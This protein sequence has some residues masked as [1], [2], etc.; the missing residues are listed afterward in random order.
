MTDSYHFGKLP[1]ILIASLIFF[2]QCTATKKPMAEANSKPSI[3]MTVKG[4]NAVATIQNFTH[5]AGC[6]YLFR[7]KDGTLLLPGELPQTDIPFY[8][9]AGIKIGY[10]VLDKDES[11]VSKAI[12]TSQDHIVRITCIEE[13]RIPEDG[14]PTKHQDCETINNPYKY[15]WMRNAITKWN[16]IRV[17]EYKYTIGYIY[18]VK[19]KD[20]STLFDCLGNEMCTT[21]DSDC[22]SLLETLESPKVILVVNNQ[23]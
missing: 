11:V 18:E 20:G 19:Y 3:P 22:S 5:E 21:E 1:L 12:C 6:Q 8:D 15:Q 13:Y 10:E 4:C 7:L 14:V 16:P 2:A 17:N 9:N 23:K